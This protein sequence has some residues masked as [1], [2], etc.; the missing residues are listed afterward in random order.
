MCRFSFSHSSFE[1]AFF[2]GGDNTCFK[3]I[4][5]SSNIIGGKISPMIG[6]LGGIPQSP[7]FLGETITTSLPRPSRN[8][9][10]CIFL[11][12][13]LHLQD[14]PKVGKHTI[15]TW[16]LSDKNLQRYQGFYAIATCRLEVVSTKTSEKLRLCCAYLSFFLGESEL[17]TSGVLV[18]WSIDRGVDDLFWES[19]INCP[20][21]DD[22]PSK[23]WAQVIEILHHFGSRQ[24]DTWEVLE[25][26]L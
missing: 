24:Y 3:T 5:T 22:F 21:W 13:C 2:W 23:S 20:T 1:M 11:Y 14:D 12:I 25:S 18:P 26:E 9:S 15:R 10:W 4:L 7:M 8:L 16:R 17:A 6:D 19:K